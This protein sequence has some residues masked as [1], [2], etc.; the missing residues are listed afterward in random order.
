MFLLISD[1]GFVKGENEVFVAQWRT[2]RGALPGK[3]NLNFFDKLN[4]VITIFLFVVLLHHM[5]IYKKQ[6]A[7]R[8][9]IFDIN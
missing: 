7:N 5:I 2:S 1:K 6:V 4:P 9:Y 3:K 8:R